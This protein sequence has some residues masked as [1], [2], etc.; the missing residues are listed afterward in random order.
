MNIE[1]YMSERY[2][3]LGESNEL[4]TCGKQYKIVEVDYHWDRS[5]GKV[6]LYNRQ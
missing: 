5:L 2:Y 1:P 3:Y 4:F 6:V